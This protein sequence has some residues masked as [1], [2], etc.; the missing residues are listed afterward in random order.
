MPNDVPA[1]APSPDV[2]AP[3]RARR[4]PTEGAAVAVS[5]DDALVVTA[6]RMGASVAVF[7]VAWSDQGPTPTRRA[8]LPFPDGEPWAVVLGNDGDT[9]YVTL[10]RSQEVVE[11]RGLR[12]TPAVARRVRV[13]SEPTGLAISP[14][15]RRLFVANMADGTVSEVETATMS[16]LRSVDLNAH[17]APRLGPN[18][19][20][21]PGLAHPRALSVTNDGDLDDGDETVYV[22]D[23]FGQ[24]ISPAPVGVVGIDVAREGL[25]YRF[26]AGSGVAS[27]P[28]ALPPLEDT[29]FVDSYGLATGC[30]PSQLHGVTL[31]GGRLYVPTVC[32]SPRG[33]VGPA[34][35][36]R[37]DANFRKEVHS[38][39]YAVDLAQGLEVPRERAL[40]TR[41]VD[42][43]YT[44]AMTADDASRRMPLIPAAIAFAPSGGAA[45]VAAYGADALF[46]V[47]YGADGALE[48]VAAPG[49]ASFIDLRASDGNGGALPVGVAYAVRGTHA[50]AL[51]EGTG[52]LSVVSDTGLNV[53]RTAPAADPPAAGLQALISRGRRLFATGTGR[54]SLRGQAWNSCESCHPDGLSDGVTWFFP[55]GPRQT[56]SLDGTY[57][58]DGNQRI[59]N[60]TAMFDEVHDFE[61]N[62]RNNSGGVGAIVHRDGDGSTPPRVTTAD[63]IVFDG[64]EAVP[65]QLATPGS[66]AGLDGSTRLLLPEFL[67]SVRSSRDDWRAIDAYVRA[68][69]SPRAPSNLDPDDVTAGRA[70]FEAGNCQG[71][72][73]GAGWTVSRRWYSPGPMT[74]DPMMG[75][76]RMTAYTLPM[77]FPAALNPPANNSTRQAMLRLTGDPATLGANDQILCVLRSVGTFP[78]SLDEA[79]SGVAPSGVSVLEWRADM[80]TT[81]QGASGYNP[82][83]LVGVAL[84]APYFHAGNA[85][86][87]EEAL[88]AT[89]ATHA[90]AL[91]PQFLT[92]TKTR[93]TQV[94]QL[95]AFLLSLDDAATPFTGPTSLGYETDLCPRM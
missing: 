69:R 57:D 31:R 32:A 46:R 24:P 42:A 93:A 15:G 26:A 56:P 78:T 20:A 4:A 95:V 79:R 43:L 73:G 90:R 76:L 82:P 89:F 36:S 27:D 72:H 30:F 49:A 62:T 3:L 23:F 34:T 81:A 65:P 91:S 5:E 6:N 59:L 44:R 28:I 40:L 19:V 77:E 88:S 13:G 25:V 55:R 64:T 29:G 51:S 50:F 22:A 61:L 67:A 35:D 54:W 14:T 38:V 52:M 70:L 9:A 48:E 10:R 84:G 7:D 21:R 68:I 83:S 75:S 37:V 18:G 33:P 87:L 2:P 86:T 80:R 71:C 12:G 8:L 39:V 41:E 47:R 63:R 45:M 74:N 1:D 11:V 16:V 53:A 92:N 58:S 17:L 60:W 66:N 94:R 85:R